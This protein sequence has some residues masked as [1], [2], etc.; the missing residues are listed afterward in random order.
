VVEDLNIA[1]MTRSARGTAA[2]PGKNV[3][4][5]AGLNRAILS[6]AAEN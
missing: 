1:G 6:T 3:K 5:K 4:A 2:C